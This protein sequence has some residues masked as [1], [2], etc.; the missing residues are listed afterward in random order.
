MLCKSGDLYIISCIPAFV[1]LCFCAFI[2]LCCFVQLLDNVADGE[3]S[4]ETADLKLPLEVANS[5]ILTKDKELMELQEEMEKTK[6]VLAKAS[7]QLEP[8]LLSH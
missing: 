7:F 2:L 8:N 5:E 4:A 1:L 6:E 3:V